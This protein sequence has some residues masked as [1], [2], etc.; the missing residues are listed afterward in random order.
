MSSLGFRAASN[1]QR[2]IARRIRK[3]SERLEE[4]RHAHT[5]SRSELV[6]R[7]H[8]RSALPQLDL[9]D[10]A[11]GEAGAVRELLEGELGL[12]PLRSDAA[13]DFGVQIGLEVGLSQYARSLYDFVL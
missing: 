10:Q 12:V 3:D 1:A 9:R 7:R 5:Q 6:H 8:R 2:R 4:V 11:D 13:T